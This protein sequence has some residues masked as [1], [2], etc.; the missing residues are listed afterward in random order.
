MDFVILEYDKSEITES[1]HPVAN[2]T[3]ICLRH[4]SQNSLQ[5]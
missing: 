1:D 4:R 3:L 2:G 5:P